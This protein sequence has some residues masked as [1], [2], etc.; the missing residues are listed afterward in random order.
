MAT[1]VENLEGG[2][3][4]EDKKAGDVPDGTKGGGVRV[5]RSS[6]EVTEGWPEL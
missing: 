1:L 2:T 5:Q 6:A 3:E 4:G